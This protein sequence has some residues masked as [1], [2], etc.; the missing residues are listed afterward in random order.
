[1]APTWCGKIFLHRL[2][3]QLML[4][5]EIPPPSRHAFFQPRDR[6]MGYSPARTAGAALSLNVWT[7]LT[8]FPDHQ[9]E[10]QIQRRDLGRFAIEKLEKAGCGLLANGGTGRTN[11]GQSRNHLARPR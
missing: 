5:R 3:G 4:H 8:A 9:F 11:R 7:A 1:L 10:T 2:G 6:R